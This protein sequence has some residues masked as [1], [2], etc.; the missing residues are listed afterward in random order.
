MSRIEYW[1]DPGAPSPNSLVPACGVLAVDDRGRLLLQRRRDTEQWALPMGKMELGE[2][3][4][5]C[6]IRETLEET[7]VDVTLTG[8]LGVYSDP[9]HIVEYGDG[10]IRQEYELIFLARPL[11]GKPAINDEASDVRWVT[12]DALAALDI[13]PTQWRQLRDYFD[14][15]YPH[16][17]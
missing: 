5:E 10:E 11:G 4:S 3:P 2:R 13:H 7:G 16:V 6:A 1:N 14:H 15:T 9:R 12:P 17:D 8:L